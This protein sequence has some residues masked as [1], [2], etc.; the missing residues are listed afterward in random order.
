MSDMNT[1]E[2]TIKGLGAL[3]LENT[4]AFSLGASIECGEVSDWI[5][6]ISHARSLARLGREAR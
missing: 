6:S 4:M 3:G 2:K 5:D 1:S